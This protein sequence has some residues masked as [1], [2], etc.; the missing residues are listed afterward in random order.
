M[1]LRNSHN[2]DQLIKLIV[3]DLETE[4]HEAIQSNGDADVLIVKKALELAE[5]NN[6]IVAADDTDILVLLCYHWKNDLYKIYFSTE[7]SEKRKALGQK[8]WS[9]QSIAESLPLVPYILFAHAWSG[10]DTTSALY[11]KGKYQIIE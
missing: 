6:V 3:H 8:F 7:S 2:K 4:G 1:F 11:M 10:C 5:R 9:I